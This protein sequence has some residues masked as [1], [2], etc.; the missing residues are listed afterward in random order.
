MR[1]FTIYHIVTA[2]IIPVGEGPRAVPADGP[3]R[4]HT[5]PVSFR[6]G[7]G[8]CRLEIENDKRD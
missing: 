4:G 6:E 3:L 2:D 1:R 7:E 8:Y 5:V